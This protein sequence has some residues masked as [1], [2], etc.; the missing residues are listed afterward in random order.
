MFRRTLHLISLLLMLG[1]TAHAGDL[2]PGKPAPNARCPVCGMYPARTPQW[3]AQII[4]ND[5]SASSFDSPL[6]LFRFLNN[7]ALFDKSHRPGDIGAIFVTDY[8]TRSW[9]EARKAFFVHGSSARGPM[10]EP[11]LPA[12]AS[13]EGADAFARQQGGRVLAFDEV[14]RDVIKSLNTGH[15][16]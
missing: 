6:D 10:Q 9:A 7:M 12:F 11:N 13:R 2:I 4:F 5:Q 16:H 8:T 1:A 3:T 15:H 14:S